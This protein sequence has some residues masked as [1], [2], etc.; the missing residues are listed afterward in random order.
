VVR[1]SVGSVPFYDVDMQVE[2]L[3]GNVEMQITAGD[4]GVIQGARMIHTSGIASTAATRR[5][6]DCSTAIPLARTSCRQRGKAL[7]PVG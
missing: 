1:P 2:G 5:C 3:G 7:G 4:E 6:W